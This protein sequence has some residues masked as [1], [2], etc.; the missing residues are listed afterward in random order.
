MKKIIL[1]L[2]L[3]CF[4]SSVFAAEKLTVL[5]DWFLNPSHA[6]LFVAQQ[7]GYFK[8]QGLDVTLIGPAD[9][10]DPPKLV[11]AG[12]ADIAISYEPQY[13]E[14]LQAGL[15]L[16]MIGSLINKPLNCLVVLKD[17]GI[18]QISELKHKRI[19]YSG[20]GFNE[21]ILTAMLK[22]NGLSLKD[23]DAINIHYDLTQ[24]LLA[25]KVDAVIDVARTFE[26]IQ[27][28]LSGHPVTVFYPEKN[29]VPSY[30]ELIF[31]V[32]K[33]KVNDPRYKKFLIAVKEGEVYLQ[34]H[35]TEMWDAFA[36]LHPELNNPLNRQAWF[37]SLPYFAE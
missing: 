19:G 6:P 12:Q 21:N 13:K 30:S 29:G 9:P 14:Q 1:S 10:S 37:A 23:V 34:K 36:K 31:E 22:Y 11:A 26:V 27:L 28:E 24:A 15:P 4:N 18:T 20:T 32:N 3:I 33:Q 8:Q 5:L 7:E 35:P 25:K 16:V 2:L 17:S